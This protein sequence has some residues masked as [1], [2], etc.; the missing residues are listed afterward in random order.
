[1][2]DTSGWN[3]LDAAI[4]TVLLRARDYSEESMKSGWNPA[5]R[6]YDN[7]GPAKRR[8]GCAA[9]A[10]LSMRAVRDA[11]HR[12]HRHPVCDNLHRGLLSAASRSP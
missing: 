1:M 10:R 4:G 5:D 3:R 2:L 6:G 9:H 12:V 7:V 8:D 11:S